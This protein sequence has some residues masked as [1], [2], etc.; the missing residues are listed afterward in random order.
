MSRL[1]SRALTLLAGGV[2]ALAAYAATAADARGGGNGAGR[3]AGRTPVRIVALL[4]SLSEAVCALGA[5]ENLVGV[6]D[7]SNWPEALRGLPHLGG[8]DDVNV[9][10]I[11]ALRPDMVLLSGSARVAER[12]EALGLRVA[13]I[14][15]HSMHDARRMLERLG[16][17]LG[18][19]VQAA[20]LWRE[21][22]AGM[23]RVA[24]ELPPRA[25]GLRVYF[26][27]SN[28]PYGASGASFIG[29]L[30]AR[31]GAV[32]IVPAA[33]G[34]FPRLNPEFVVRADPQVL[35]I[36]SRNAM[37]LQD[38]PGWSAITAVRDGRVCLFSPAEI[39]TLVRPG[40]RMVEAAALMARCMAGAA[41][42]AATRER[43]P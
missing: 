3:D 30:L 8:L 27:V 43:T 32:N 35:M 36:G 16:Q 23:N 31:L 14:E 15:A 9:E 42:P 10:R 24:A 11:V 29:E 28:G 19:E 12:L 21:L 22:D 26:E 7:Y 39:D 20:A 18:R 40:P 1:F 13:A 38:R 25:R 4:P 34:P 33:L 17:L 6:D 41:P 2:L 37:P 5:C